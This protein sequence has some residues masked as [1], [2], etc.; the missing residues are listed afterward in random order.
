MVNGNICLQ[1][2]FLKLPKMQPVKIKLHR[3]IPEGWK[4]KSVTVSREPSGKYFASLLFDCE[5]QTAEKR[6]AEKFLGMD[7]AMHGMCVFSTGERAGYPMFYLNAEKKLAREQRKLS[8]CEKGSRNYQKQKK[9]VALYHEKIK[10]Q[11][12]DFQ[13]KLS[14]SIAKDYDAV[15]VE[16]LNLK[17]IAGGL[18]FG[19]GIQDNGYGQFLSMLGYKLEER[20][21]YLIKV[22]RYFASS[23]ICSVCGH[24]KKELALSE[25]TYLCECGNQMDR[26]V[27]AAVNILEEG[28]RIYKKCA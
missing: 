14:H 19:K 18:H 16:D 15:C 20:G 9:K 7:F 10:N 26:D 27:N 6:Q 28:K 8:R 23:K 3:M 17:G 22:D 2:R 21:K 12:K 4:L 5:N 13:H 24:K 1:D 25:R 11:R